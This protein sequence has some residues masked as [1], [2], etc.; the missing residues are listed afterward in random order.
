[1]GTRGL[2]LYMRE[3]GGGGSRSEERNEWGAVQF[4]W[5]FCGVFLYGGC[6]HAV[7]GG[8]YGRGGR[9][10]EGLADRQRER[11]IERDRVSRCTY[12]LFK[13]LASLR[14]CYG[15]ITALLRLY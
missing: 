11:I 1:M 3:E 8:E 12:C 13:T 15:S 9:V 6:G 10:W 4:H 7:M 5:L 2:L 14:L